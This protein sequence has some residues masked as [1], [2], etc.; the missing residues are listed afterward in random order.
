MIGACTGSSSE[1]KITLFTSAQNPVTVYGGDIIMTYK[2]MPQ[3]EGSVAAEHFNYSFSD[4]GALAF[5]RPE[6]RAYWRLDYE[7]GPWTGMLRG[8]WTGP[9][10]LAK[11]YDYANNPRYNFDGTPKKNKSPSYWVFDARGEYRFDRRWALYAGIDNLLDFNQNDKESML[12]IDSS[13]TIDVT[14]IWGPNRGRFIYGGVRF[15]L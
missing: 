12:W 11:F 2:I 14:Q 8:M 1:Q 10:D 6:T 15:T 7:S 13:G 5:A 9:Q 4:P 3:L